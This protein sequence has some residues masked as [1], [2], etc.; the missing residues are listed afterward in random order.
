MEGPAQPPP[1]SSSSIYQ[2]ATAAI[3]RASAV[4]KSSKPPASLQPNPEL[5]PIAEARLLSSLD[6]KPPTG[7]LPDVQF[8]KDVSKADATYL[9]LAYGSNLAAS[10]FRGVRKVRPLAALNVVVP[11]LVMTFDLAGLPYQEPCFA[12]TAYRSSSPFSSSQL[13]ELPSTTDPEKISL[14]HSD[15]SPCWLKGLVGVVYEVTA[16]DFAHIIATEG[17]GASYKD[18]L[19]TC[20]PLPASSAT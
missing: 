17:G 18:V 1:S 15:K 10:T 9:Y 11:E 20:H 8:L 12:N 6:E 4:F 3:A 7:Q 5:P 2:G 14:L 13:D 19:V 16:S